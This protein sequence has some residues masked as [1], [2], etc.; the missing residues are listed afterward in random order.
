[1]VVYARSERNMSSEWSR[2]TVAIGPARQCLID[3]V[4]QNGQ[5]TSEQVVVEPVAF[6][7]NHQGSL[8]V[9]TA[10][11]LHSEGQ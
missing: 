7:L 3:P 8:P 11:C 4:T 9:R 5:A 1:M 2:K 6:D 10:F